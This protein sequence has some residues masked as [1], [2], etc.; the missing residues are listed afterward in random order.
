MSEPVED[1]EHAGCRVV[2]EY[3]SD[4][5]NPREDYDHAATMVCEHREYNLG[6]KDGRDEANSAVRS[7][8]DYRA[9]WEDDVYTPSGNPLRYAKY[10]FNHP[11]QLWAAVQACSDIVSMPLYLYDHSGITMSTSK[12]SCHWDSGQIGFI[13][14][15]K[16]KILEEWGHKRLPP[17]QTLTKK[18]KE[19]ARACMQAEVEEY[20]QYLTGQ[21]YCFEVTAPDGC[22]ESCCGFYG[23]DA[24]VDEAKLVAEAQGKAHGHADTPA[25][26]DTKATATA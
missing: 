17:Q 9:S 23:L 14:L 5:Q 16:D 11:A 19:Q 4:P 18:L 12:F 10:D 26:E 21:I 3:D 6:D 8:R 24:A 1:F 7:S 25:T 22:E 20:D 13:F 2:I 15:T